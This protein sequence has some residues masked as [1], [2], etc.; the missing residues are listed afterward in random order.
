MTKD[1]SKKIMYVC[2]SQLNALIHIMFHSID[3]TS[4]I[5][6]PSKTNHKNEGWRENNRKAKARGQWN[7][8]FVNQNRF[9]ANE[10]ICARFFAFNKCHSSRLWP[11][12]PCVCSHWLWCQGMNKLCVP[13]EM[14]VY[15]YDSIWY[16]IPF[17]SRPL[18]SKHWKCWIHFS[19]SIWIAPNRVFRHCHHRVDDNVE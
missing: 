9:E 11:F 1:S 3:F 8:S 17:F 18:N 5:I 10:T 4:E 7:S 16:V 6:G 19:I 2:I 12:I 13:S 14:Y 15:I